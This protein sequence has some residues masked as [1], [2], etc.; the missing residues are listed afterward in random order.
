MITSND[1]FRVSWQC[2]DIDIDEMLGEGMAKLDEV[3]QDVSRAHLR[4]FIPG[5]PC[6]AQLFQELS[7]E[8]GDG[9][10][11]GYPHS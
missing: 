2:S 6:P 3:F 5:N 11:A 4:A 8:E 1:V 9:A 10:G 7:P